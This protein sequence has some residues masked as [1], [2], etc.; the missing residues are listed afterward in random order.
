MI[1]LIEIDLRY[2]SFVLEW[3]IS[4]KMYEITNSSLF[5]PKIIWMSRCSY[6]NIE[7]HNTQQM[8][9]RFISA[10]GR[11]ML[12]TFDASNVSYKC[13]LSNENNKIYLVYTK[14]GSD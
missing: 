7:I 2:D 10:G 3:N 1:I 8:E 14:L 5:A 13:K 6:M 9:F 4:I 12:M 11:C